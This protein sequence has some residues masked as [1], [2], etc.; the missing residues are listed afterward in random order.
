MRAV[1]YTHCRPITAD[2]ALSDIALPIDARDLKEKSASLHW[3][4]MFTRALY[5]TPTSS[6]SRTC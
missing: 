5:D 3:E 6:S 1:A 4:A 2:D